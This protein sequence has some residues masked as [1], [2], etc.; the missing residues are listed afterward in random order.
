MNLYEIW[1]RLVLA[2]NQADQ[3]NIGCG[4]KFS[5][6]TSVAECNAA[7]TE[8]FA[9]DTDEYYKLCA[10][11]LSSQLCFVEDEEVRKFFT[12]LGVTF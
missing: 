2:A 12:N 3:D 9:A 6:Q 4:A 5:Y 8:G 1:N 11:S 7:E 10:A